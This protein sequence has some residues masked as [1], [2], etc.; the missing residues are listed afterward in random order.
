MESLSLDDAGEDLTE[1]LTLDS[2]LR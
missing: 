1:D 2:V